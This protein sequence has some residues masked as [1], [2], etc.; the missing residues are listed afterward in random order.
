LQKLHKDLPPS[1]TMLQHAW[2]TIMTTDPLVDSDEELGDDDTR[3]DYMQRMSILSRIRGKSPTP[4]PE[5]LRQG[6]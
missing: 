3:L 1:M 4:E 2:H 6:S 5:L